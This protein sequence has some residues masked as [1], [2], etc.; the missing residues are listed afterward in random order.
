MVSLERNDRVRKQAV[1]RPGGTLGI[2]LSS[3][4]DPFSNL[5]LSGFTSY[6]R[7][8]DLNVGVMVMDGF[9]S[10]EGELGAYDIVDP[11]RFDGLVLTGALTYREERG[12]DRLRALRDRYPDLR[13]VGILLDLE[14][15]ISVDADGYVGMREAVEHLID[16]HGYRRLA[17]IGGPASSRVAEDRY[18]AYVDAL[19]SRDIPLLDDLVL[20]G[21]FTAEAGARGVQ[22]LL[23]LGTDIDALVCSNDEAAIGALEA[24]RDRGIRVPQDIAVVGFDD[25]EEA[26]QV[27]VPLTTVRQPL[28]QMGWRAAEILHHLVTGVDVEE[29]PDIPT[30]LVVRRSCGCLPSVVTQAAGNPE[31]EGDGGIPEP[32]ALAAYLADVLT[33][34]EPSDHQP[35]MEALLDD[36]NSSESDEFI[37][38][39][40]QALSE[41]EQGDRAFSQW[42]EALTLLRRQLLGR[43]EN[44]DAGRSDRIR[45]FE[46]LLQQARILVGQAESRSLAHRQMIV[47]Q[48]RE[49]I[50]SFQ[51]QTAS[52][53]SL[54][55]LVSCFADVLPQLQLDACDL[56][57]LV[58]PGER[59]QPDDLASLELS[60]GGDESDVS[61]ENF[62][63]NRLLPDETWSV[64]LAATPSVFSVLPMTAGDEEF[65]ASVFWGQPDDFGVCNQLREAVTGIAQRAKLLQEQRAAVR[66]AEE[67]SRRADLALRDA[68]IAQQRYVEQAWEGYE[69]PIRGYQ[70]SPEVQGPTQTEWVSGMK[71]AL[72]DNDCAV[73]TDGGEE[74]LSLPLSLLGEEIIGVLG[75]TRDASTGWTEEEIRTAQIVAEQAALALENQ[76]LVSDV[77]RRAARLTAAS[78]VSSAATSLT[79]LG[80]LLTRVVELIRSQFE[81]YYAGI[82]L[83][84]EAQ[85]WAVLVAGSGEAGRLML[86]QGHRLEV[87]GESM[88]GDCVATGNARITYDARREE[89]HRPHPLLPDTRSELALPLISRGE[90][91]GAMTIQDEQPGAFTEDDITILQT[92]AAQLANAITNARLLEQME[93]NVRELRAATG[94]YTQETW[95]EYLEQRPGTRGYRYRLV[96]VT[97]VTD[98]RAEAVEAWDQDRTVV[99]SLDPEMSIDEREAVG[100]PR[101]EVISG[102]GGSGIGVPIRLRNQTLGVL[103]VRFEDEEVP[104]ETVRLVEQVAGRLALALESAR[105]L[106]EMRRTAQRE[107]MIGDVTDRMRR[108]LDWDELMQTTTQELRTLLDASRVFVQWR[109]PQTDGST[110][111]GAEE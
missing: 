23:Q 4:G 83:V 14:H 53:T 15:V 32:E 88:I 93:Q 91:I 110:G 101:T 56:A 57:T 76:R 102:N 84:D 33:G 19:T 103:N 22:T 62:P 98:R 95:R 48:R 106:T 10:A 46:G 59:A 12:V 27:V 44:V 64:R 81:L 35:L 1:D 8:N 85:Q 38:A 86:A 69:A 36:L 18:R 31:R 47:N 51:G 61:E 71:A 97:S 11:E 43:L 17:F 3:L 37:R 68:L 21:D 96:D 79:D 9:R 89:R 25:V 105:L 2:L 50:E 72:R 90:V 45:R 60:Y 34:S 5:L 111:D 80:E 28:Y 94:Q 66:A 42:H 6:T 39:L 40:D 77:Q 41:I 63:L 67:E 13:L 20:P 70:V 92:M 49:A 30:E 108:T 52:L 55:E 16:V 7:T 109:T 75:F 100:A 74:T 29:S 107:R 54:E 78:E 104:S 99:T 58:E 82:F 24:L 26:A 73:E 65:G 87:S